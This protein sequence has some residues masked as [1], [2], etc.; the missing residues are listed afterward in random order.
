MVGEGNEFLHLVALP[1]I[2]APSA[3]PIPTVT[4]S[5]HLYCKPLKRE[6]SL[7]RDSEI[8]AVQF[9]SGNGQ[10]SDFPS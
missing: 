6:Y 5:L 1:F 8:M 10:P 2:L 7:T 4:L 9:I 3:S